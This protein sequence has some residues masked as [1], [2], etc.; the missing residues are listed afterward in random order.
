MRRNETCLVVLVLL[1]ALGCEEKAITFD[2]HKR[3]PQE[4][5]LY[6]MK[7]TDADLRYKTLVELAKSKA[8]KDDWAVKAMLIVARSDPSPSV[9]ALAV[10]NLGRVGDKRVL[11]ML[12]EAMDDPEDRVR[13]EAAWGLSQMNIVESGAE[14]KDIRSA[15]SVLLQALS[16]DVCVD[17]RLNA[18]RALGQFKD[19]MVLKALIA[20]LKDT[21][22]AVRYESELS[23]VKLTGRTFQGNS[24]RW[25]AWMDETKDPFQDAGRVPPE[26]AQPKRNLFQQTGDGL[27][28]FYLD[29]Q[30][31]AKR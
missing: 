20:A 17:V 26:L 18:A 14:A 25:V 7:S 21:D 6:A 3:T 11:A 29:W 1:M 2:L 13:L 5:A 15:Q 28:Q 10:H 19:R 16:S 31:P 30:G 9:R 27:Y 22:F 4:S 23:L 12:V 8:L 24:G